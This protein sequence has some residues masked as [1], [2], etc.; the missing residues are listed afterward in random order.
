MHNQS[1]TEVCVLLATYNGEKFLQDQFN[2]LLNQDHKKLHVHVA[3]DG[4]SDSTREIVNEY[5]KI[6]LVKSITKFERLTP[7]NIFLELLLLACDGNPVAFCDQ[8]DVWAPYKTS[9]SLK[10]LN[11]CDL[12]AGQRDSFASNSSKSRTSRKRIEPSLENAL[13]QNILYGNTIM[14]SGDAARNAKKDLYGFKNHLMHD[15][16]IYLYF[17]CFGRIKLV[18]APLIHYRIHSDNY[19]GLGENKSFLRII[20]SLQD[21]HLQVKEFSRI[22]A[23]KLSKPDLHTLELYLDAF[24]SDH[25]KTRFSLSLKL[26]IR[27]ISKLETFL[28]KLHIPFMKCFRLIK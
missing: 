27:R 6:G 26:K 17:A 3:D 24:E 5:M 23:H 28:I 11:D 13:V 7:K 18:D 19:I 12:V 22:F 9:F 20:Y 8:D 14:L 21:N 4:S 2:S 25:L 10:A 16:L 15:S 1:E